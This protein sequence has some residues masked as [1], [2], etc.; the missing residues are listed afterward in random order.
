MKS[1]LAV[2]LGV[3]ML[4]LVAAKPAQAHCQIPCGIFDDMLR[5][6][7]MTEDITTIERS[8]KAI[9]DLAG[10]TSAAD[11]NQVVRWVENKDHHA[12]LLAETVSEYFLRQRV[13]APAGDDAA[14][15][16]KY[17]DQLIALH[18]LLVTS[19]KAKQAVDL[20]TVKAMRDQL[21]RFKSLYFTPEQLA[22]GAAHAH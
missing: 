14:A 1:T 7:M 21:E 6:D 8:I 17:A 22:Q 13:K 18:G 4:A 9:A 15:A 19:M 12:D 11:I 10:K 3:A 2:A 16:K 5:I 20:D